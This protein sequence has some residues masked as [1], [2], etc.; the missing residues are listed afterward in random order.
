VGV[1]GTPAILDWEVNRLPD[2]YRQP[3][4][5]CYLEGKINEQAAAE[6]GCPLGTVLSRLARARDRLRARLT[7]RGLTLSVAG[8]AGALGG[9]AAQGAAPPGLT[10]AAVTSG[11]AFAGGTAA[12]G[13]A[14][15]AGVR[16]LA[17]G[18]LRA[19]TWTRL[20]K[21]GAGLLALAAGMAVL[22]LLL[23]RPPS[24]PP[25]T[26]RAR[27]QGTWRALSMEHAGR[28]VPDPDLRFTF[29]G[30]QTG[31]ITARF[32]TPPSPYTLDPS[33][34]PKAIDFALERGTQ[35]GI[36]RLDG[37][38]LTLC[39]DHD[40]ARGKR[41]AALHAPPDAPSVCVYIL[42]HE[43]SAREIEAAATTK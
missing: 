8:L 6:L 25:L 1:A 21:A 9:A 30:D 41:P 40:P 23:R 38:L 33:Q 35:R 28:V 39:L 31:L 4:V 11:L 26:D 29:V 20:F 10:E 2:K 42:R 14:V 12:A 15:A 3:F 17:D 36:Y 5:L 43:P 18:F 37:D 16:V 22:L 24:P 32:Q 19:L 13:G 27:L 34:E 7:R